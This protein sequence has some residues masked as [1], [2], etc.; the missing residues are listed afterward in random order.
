MFVLFFLSI[1]FHIAVL[2][3]PF[4]ENAPCLKINII[5]INSIT[6]ANSTRFPKAKIPIYIAS[7][8]LF[9]KDLIS[10]IVHIWART[11]I[12]FKIQRNL[13]F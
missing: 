8:Y 11:I 6:I 1:L 7:T 9:K 10:S 3:T 4:C 2:K 5:I 13:K 12:Y